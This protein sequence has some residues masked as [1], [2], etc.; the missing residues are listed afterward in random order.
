MRDKR[1]FA[2]AYMFLVTAFFSS[3]VI[4]FSQ[5]TRARVEA[6]KTLAFEKA[7]LAA[8]PELFVPDAGGLELH[9]RFTEQVTAPQNSTGGAYVLKE[10]G[11][12]R[13]YALP[14]AGQGFWAPIKG[15]IGLRSDRKTITGIAFY[16]QNETPGLGAQITTISFR[17]QFKG[18]VLSAGDKPLGLKRAGELLSESDVHAVTGATQTSMRLEEII[19]A[20]VNS[21]R[22]R[23]A[24]GTM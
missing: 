19:N 22:S 5:F 10:N 18:K 2:V 8:L 24:E 11:Q 14:I 17:S 6:N 3:I 4:G 20:A 21:W 16:E 7:I 15:V 1:W 13:A 9:R 12:V 23:L